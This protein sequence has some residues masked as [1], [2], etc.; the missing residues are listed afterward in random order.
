[1][2]LRGTFAPKELSALKYGTKMNRG[3]KSGTGVLYWIFL[4]IENEE[5]GEDIDSSNDDVEY[6]PPEKK[7]QCKLSL[8][9]VGKKGF[10]IQCY[11]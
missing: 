7:D 2:S 6:R 1:M 8:E 10:L 9:L 3:N 11:Y 5:H 4:L